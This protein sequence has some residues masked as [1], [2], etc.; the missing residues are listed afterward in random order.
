[1]FEQII[2]FIISVFLLG[3]IMKEVN[4][5]VDAENELSELRMTNKASKIRLKNNIKTIKKDIAEIAMY[6]ARQ[7]KNISNE[8]HGALLRKKV[9]LNGLEAQLSEMITVEKSTIK[10]LHG[11]E[12]ESALA[13]LFYAFVIIITIA[14]VTGD[15][16][17]LFMI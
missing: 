10:E 13:I 5:I 17:L 7:Y 1:M 2:A 4:R 14:I 16:R 11:Q 9:N 3:L 8:R 6:N 15:I 12:V